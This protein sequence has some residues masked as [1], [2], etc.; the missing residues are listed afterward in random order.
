[1]SYKD[2]EGK[3]VP[4][5]L[6]KQIKSKWRNV[7]AA[8][9]FPPQAIKEIKSED[10]PLFHLLSEWLEGANQEHDTRPLTWR[11]LITALKEADIQGVANILE[12]YLI[13]T[14]PAQETESQSGQCC[15]F[16]YTM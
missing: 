16:V 14:K 9:E 2:E 13:V 8:L 1:M 7:A 11:T 3:I 5:R 12:K 15:V 10:D 4:F 6:M